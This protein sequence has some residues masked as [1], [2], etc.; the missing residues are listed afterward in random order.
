M[1]TRLD[2]AT[3]SKENDAEI[4]ADGA[5]A[6][7]AGAAAGALTGGGFE[8]VRQRGDWDCGLA[9]LEM[10]LRRVRVR[11]SGVMDAPRSTV[12]TVDLL[13]LLHRF[14]PPGCPLEYTTTCAGAP[15]ASHFSLEFYAKAPGDA[16]RVPLAFA[17]ARDRGLTVREEEADLGVVAAELGA[18]RAC[19]VA[20]LTTDFC[21]A[22]YAAPG[23]ARPA[24]KGTTLCSL[25]ARVGLFIIWTPLAPRLAAAARSSFARFPRRGPRRAPIRTCCGWGFCKIVWR[26]SHAE[27]TK[28]HPTV[29]ASPHLS[30]VSWPEKGGSPPHAGRAAPPP[31]L[32]HSAAPAQFV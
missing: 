17:T 22:R 19:F 6:G 8:H 18:G 25:G 1:A 11:G 30:T 16:E 3:N 32:R 12:W 24:T 4:G 14:L 7:V 20:L 5:G 31:V 26:F 29:P 2:A 13:L 27:G 21:A 15:P 28:A 9:C 10:V 23:V